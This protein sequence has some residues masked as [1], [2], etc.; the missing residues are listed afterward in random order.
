VDDRE[1]YLETPL[2]LPLPQSLYKQT[3]GWTDGWTF[4][5][6]YADIITKFSRLDGLAIFLTH[7]ASLACFARLSSAIMCP[8]FLNRGL[9]P[10]ICE[11]AEKKACPWTSEMDSLAHSG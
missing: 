8:E 1:S 6:S 10:T 2:P 9:K 3:D 4:A 7:V 11:A 5:R